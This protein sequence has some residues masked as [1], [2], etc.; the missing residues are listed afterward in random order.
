MKN[1]KDL[2]KH[3][4]ATTLNFLDI[5]HD[6]SRLY[7]YLLG[8]GVSNISNIAKHFGISRPYLYKLIGELVS[9][10]LVTFN[11][12]VGSDRLKILP[13]TSILQKLRS[14]KKDIELTEKNFLN[15][16]PDLMSR[17]EQGSQPAKVRVITGEKDFIDLL[18]SIA[19]EESKLAEYF[20]SIQDFIDLISWDTQN[21]WLKTRVE[22]NIKMHALFLP[23][24]DARELQR[25]D[26]EQLRES[27]IHL[28]DDP[29]KT[30]FHLFSNKV[31]F[32]QPIGKLAVVVEDQYIYRM[33]KSIFNTLWD[34]AGERYKPTKETPQTA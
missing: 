1:Q 18:F 27:R 20:G 26:K 30:S 8:S 3:A 29:F 21:K 5:S 23:S 6:A 13:P 2:G 22:K 11:K 4:I 25:K 28:A 14:Q 17:Y 16:L 34:L 19:E 32:W 31:I 7:E 10:E 9:S 24:D 15:T 12:E 33:M